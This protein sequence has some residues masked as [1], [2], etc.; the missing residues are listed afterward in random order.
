MFDGALGG[1]TG[2]DALC[3]A[4]AESAASIVAPGTYFAWLSDST[5]SPNTRFTRSIGTYRLPDKTVVAFD[6]RDLTD[7]S[8]AAR[9]DLD[10]TGIP[11]QE[12]IG[13]WTNT[14]PGGDLDVAFSETS[15]PCLNWTIS[16]EGTFASF[17]DTDKV[18]VLWT[19]IGRAFCFG[20]KHLYCFQQ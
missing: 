12:N 11:A 10:E 8:L 20:E 18:N 9:I 16:G 2:A 4:A 6:Y 14:T 17:G 7:G 3:Q 1:L 5:G 13:A 19:Q 15:E